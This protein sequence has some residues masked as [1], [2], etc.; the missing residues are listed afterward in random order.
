[1]HLILAFNLNLFLHKLNKL[2]TR[3]L[4]F[5][6]M[7][8]HFKKTSKLFYLY[9]KVFHTQTISYSRITIESHP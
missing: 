5:S 2:S 1:M 4:E 9:L 7:K 8:I 3:L 6:L